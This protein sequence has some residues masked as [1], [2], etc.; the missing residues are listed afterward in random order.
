VSYVNHSGAGHAVHVDSA[1]ELD[2]RRLL[3]IIVDVRH[4]PILSRWSR[5]YTIKSVLQELRRLMLLKENMKLSQPPE[6][7]TY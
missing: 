2:S 1:D 7:S 4:V 5:E 3:R 6:G